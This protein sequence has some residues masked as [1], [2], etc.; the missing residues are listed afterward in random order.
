MKVKNETLFHQKDP[1][2][3]SK[4]SPHQFSPSHTL[5]TAKSPQPAHHGLD[6]TRWPSD[7]VK[8]HIYWKSHSQHLIIDVI[9]IVL[10]AKKLLASSEHSFQ[11]LP[12]HHEA[13]TSRRPSRS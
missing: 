2:P 12:V 9:G 5:S 3:R 7:H 10:E 6:T 4:W 11:D 8:V 1:L 13:G